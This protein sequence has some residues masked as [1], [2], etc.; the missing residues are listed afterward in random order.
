[1]LRLA[2]DPCADPS[3]RTAACARLET[4]TE[5][6]ERL[7][8]EASLAATAHPGVRQALR[9]TL[10]GAR[11]RVA[12]DAEVAPAHEPDVDAIGTRAGRAA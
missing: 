9:D 4:A 6:E 7:A 2:V 11:V 1:V 5:Q 3:A 12:R 8:L 10:K